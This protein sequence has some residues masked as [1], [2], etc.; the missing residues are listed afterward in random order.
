MSS[1]SGSTSRFRQG[2]FHASLLLEVNVKYSAVRRNRICLVIR[3][4][5]LLLDVGLDFSVMQR[6]LTRCL[7]IKQ[8]ISQ[9]FD[10][11]LGGAIIRTGELSKPCG[12]HS[13]DDRPISIIEGPTCKSLG[14]NHLS[15]KALRC[16]Q[17]VA[18]QGLCLVSD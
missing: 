5:I 14:Q 15:L 12:G 13:V 7:E 11:I 17:L 4:T 10:E 6:D 16:L 9:L 2:L 8:R 18:G 1:A 3:A